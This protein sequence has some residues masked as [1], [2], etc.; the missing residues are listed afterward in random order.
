MD[1]ISNKGLQMV[2]LI[3]AQ[4]KIQ[5]SVKKW[6]VPGNTCIY[7]LWYQKKFKKG[8]IEEVKMT[9]VELDMMNKQAAIAN[10]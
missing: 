4:G 10:G 1:I 6:K 3:L 2:Y 5:G 9:S 8:V 7:G